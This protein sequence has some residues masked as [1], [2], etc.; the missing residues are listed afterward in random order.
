MHAILV[1]PFMNCPTVKVINL[2][3]TVTVIEERAIP[4][5]VFVSLMRKSY[6]KP[7]PERSGSKEKGTM[8]NGFGSAFVMK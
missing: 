3:E 5:P 1:G 2:P 7:D 6:G 8:E 4:V